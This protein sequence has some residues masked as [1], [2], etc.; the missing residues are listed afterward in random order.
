[1]GVLDDAIKEHL[2]LKRKH[3]VPEEELQRQEEEALGPARRDVA[4][5]PEDDTE[6][7]PGQ[8]V[9]ADSE[10]DGALVRTRVYSDPVSARAYRYDQVT[11]ADQS[12][13]ISYQYAAPGYSQM[14]QADSSGAYYY[15]NSVGYEVASPRR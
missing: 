14:Y 1:M 6:L 5:Q 3:G 8:P 13:T 9:T 12:F 4:Q 2:E 15:R 10:G 11:G 7:E